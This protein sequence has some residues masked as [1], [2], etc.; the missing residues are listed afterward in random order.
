MDPTCDYGTTAPTLAPPAPS[1]QPLATGSS[2]H[3]DVTN[4]A[5]LPTDTATATEHLLASYQFY[6]DAS[7][8]DTPSSRIT[9]PPQRVSNHVTPGTGHA[10]QTSAT[11]RHLFAQHVIHIPP[12]APTLGVDMHELPFGIP[13]EVHS[14]WFQWPSHTTS[15]FSPCC[16][17]LTAQAQL[18]CRYVHLQYSISRRKRLLP[19][20]LGFTHST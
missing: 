7:H 18:I 13:A 2:P 4:P 10:D 14:T 16:Q 1:H 3:R 6:A 17:K 11:Q 5:S 8:I 20:S 19:H 15:R 9:T 12:T